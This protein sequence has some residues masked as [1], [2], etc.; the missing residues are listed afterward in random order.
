MHFLKFL[1]LEFTGLAP[2]FPILIIFYNNLIICYYFSF[3]A[4]IPLLR[5]VTPAY[6]T[7]VATPGVWQVFCAD[8]GEGV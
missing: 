3:S 1:L 5:P 2:T 6:D 4:S 7:G 8:K